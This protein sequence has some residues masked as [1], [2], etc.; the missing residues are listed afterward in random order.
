MKANGAALLSA[1]LQNATPP[2]DCRSIKAEFDNTID[3]NKGEVMVMLTTDVEEPE[4][5]VGNNEW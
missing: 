5:G 1:S 4:N 2:W 3:S